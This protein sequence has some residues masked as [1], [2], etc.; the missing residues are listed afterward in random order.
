MELLATVHWVV[1]E[2]P[3]S[4]FDKV[5]R[6]VHGWNKRKR[7]IMKPAHVKVAYDRLIAEGFLA[8]AQAA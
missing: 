5:V 8:T 2:N 7:E 3:G 1:E 6:A 4:D